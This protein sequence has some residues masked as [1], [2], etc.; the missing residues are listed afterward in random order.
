MFAVATKKRIFTPF[1]TS[2]GNRMRG[3][4]VRKYLLLDSIKS[5]LFGSEFSC[6][7]FE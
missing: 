1:T 4:H 2:L 5:G 7:S 3:K 6:M